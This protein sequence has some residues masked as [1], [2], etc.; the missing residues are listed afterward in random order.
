MIKTEDDISVLLTESEAI[1]TSLLS[2]TT[3]PFSLVAH[4]ATLNYDNYSS[5]EALKLLFGSAE[6]V[7]SSYEIIGHIAHLNLR[8]K[9][10]EIK[11][12]VGKVILDVFT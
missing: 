6:E 4:S 1:V 7:P 9:F 11:Y 2:S 12:K 3:L 5:H 10:N 8:E